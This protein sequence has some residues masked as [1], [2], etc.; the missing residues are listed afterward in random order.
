MSQSTGRRYLAIVVVGALHFL[1]LEI[2]VRAPPV[3]QGPAEEP[4]VWSTLFFLPQEEVK[5]P[6]PVKIRPRNTAAISPSQVPATR[7]VSP[8]TTP[9]SPTTAKSPVDWMSELNGA[10]AA[11]AAANGGQGGSSK[12]ESSTSGSLWTPPVHTAGEQYR[13]STGELVVWVSDRCFLVSE[14][15]MAGTPNSAAHLALTHTQCNDPG[16]RSDLFKELPAYRKY[17]PDP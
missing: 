14:P 2:F 13:L 11:V 7:S 8:M 9:P 16:P 4:T 5:R 1:I 10:A 12:E 17:R 3:P 6:Q 15:P